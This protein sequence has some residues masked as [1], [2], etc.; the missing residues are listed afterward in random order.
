MKVVA[1]CARTISEKTR[2]SLHNE[3]LALR[4]ISCL[5]SVL[6][7]RSFPEPILFR[8]DDCVLF[9]SALP[10]VALSRRLKW[11]ANA[12]TGRCYKPWLED[13]GWKAGRWLRKFHSMTPPGSTPHNH[14]AFIKDFQENVAHCTAL[15]MSES[16]LVRTSARAEELSRSLNGNSVSTAPSHGDFL[17]QNL[18]VYGTEIGVTD[19]AEYR[20]SAPIY[21]DVAAFL[22]YILLL[23]QKAKYSDDALEKLANSFVAG[24]GEGYSKDLVQLYMLNAVLRMVRDH[25]FQVV[26][27]DYPHY[28]ESALTE[29]VKDDVLTSDW[30][31]VS[32]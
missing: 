27:R 11:R 7:E 8:E 25:P 14:G 16:I 12:I 29:M 21:L 5:E 32:R 26:T 19:F 20:S 2:A 17:P 23:Q 13:V 24:Y 31:S 28:V 30:L 4:E 18:L 22:A 10:G 6:P 3:Y 15:G 9:M 1:K